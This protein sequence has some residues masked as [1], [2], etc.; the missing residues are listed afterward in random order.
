M[1]LRPALGGNLTDM[2]D[3]SPD[4]VPGYPFPTPLPIPTAHP[5]MNS[6]GAAGSAQ[7]RPDDGRLDIGA[8]E[9]GD[10]SLPKPDAPRGLHLE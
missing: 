3:S 5:P 1:D 10:T 4:G 8:F 6:I 2:A 7:V 9:A